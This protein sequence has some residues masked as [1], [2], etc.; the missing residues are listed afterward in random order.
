M[1]CFTVLGPSQSGKTTLVK[2]MSQLDGAAT[3]TETAGNLALTRFSFLD[4]PWCA[5]DVAGSAEYSGVMGSAL[6]ASDAVVLCVPSD[7]AAAVLVAPYLRVIEASG[8]PCLIFIN[9]MDAPQGR[10]EDIVAALQGY[11][12]HTIVLRQMPIREG[13]AVVGAIDLISERAWHYQEGKPSF[14]MEIP[15]SMREVEHQAHLDLME[16]LSEFDDGLLE[17]LIE[18]REPPTAELFQTAAK[19]LQDN[20]IIPAYLGAASH[21]N[22]V[23]RLMKALRHEAPSV[24]ALRARLSPA[25]DVLAVGFHA[26]FQKH[27][28]KAVYLRALTDGVKSGTNLAG[29]NLGN[30]NEFGEVGSNAL[31]AGSVGVAVKADQLNAGR[32]FNAASS[33]DGPDW[34]KSRRPTLARLLLP[35]NE[36]DEVRLSTAL[37]RLQETD[38]GLEVGQDEDSG[39]T[40]LRAQ[41]PLHLRRILASISDDFDVKV[42]EQVTPTS[43]RETISQQAEEHYRH[44]KQSGGSGQFAD[45][46]LIVRPQ[47][48][49][50]GFAF[51]E[52]VKGGAV[53]RNFISAVE[54]GAQDATVAG[55]LGFPVIDVA[56]TLTDG[57]SHAV[58]SSDHAFRTAAK[59]GTREALQK[60]SPVLLQPIER[61][62][63]H[64]PS[65]FSGSIVS[66]ISTLKGQ[67]L[68]FEPNPEARGWDVTRILL[69]SSSRDDLIRGLGTATQGTGWFESK[70]DHYQELHGKEAETICREHA[71][72]H[73]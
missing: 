46:V 27:L 42:T 38:L 56:V 21:V 13:G 66:L 41:G 48:R 72:E 55:P 67:V 64:A 29:G 32:L 43:Y 14:L 4:E 25:G 18:D 58:D 52:V 70:F 40:I 65:V 71:K 8:T 1:R 28:G 24:D 62:D 61:V 44:R 60:A 33:Q 5:F 15:S 26:E 73:A 35:T 50:A 36:R 20:K 7:P 11:S 53:P 49:G 63:I 37:A 47:E 9:K 69:P 57:K 30:L 51:D 17:Q 23:M 16:H 39:H 68:G 54:A 6:M 2:A 10:I 22:G 12:Q 34:V 19:V 3:R 45:V 31:A 59:M